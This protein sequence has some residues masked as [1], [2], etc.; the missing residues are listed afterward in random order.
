MCFT[1]LSRTNIDVVNNVRK[2]LLINNYEYTDNCDY[3]EESELREIKMESQALTVVQ[4]NIRGLFGKRD[5]LLKFLNGCNKKKIDIV[6]LEETWLNTQNNAQFSV[7]GYNFV[8]HARPNKKGG[9]VGILISNEIKYRLRK[10]LLIE[11]NPHFEN[12]S[13]EIKTCSSESILS[14]IYRPPN[15]DQKLF[16]KSFTELGNKV[17]LEKNKEWIIGLDHNMDLI[18]SEQHANTE[19]FLEEILRLELYPLITCPT[20]VTKS[21]ATLIDNILVSRSLYNK[22]SSAIIINDLSDHLPCI[23]VIDNMKSRKGETIELIKRDMKGE[24]IKQLRFALSKHNWSTIHGNIDVSAKFDYVHTTILRY[25]DQHCP[26][27]RIKI[28]NKKIIK[29]PWLFKGLIKCIDKQKKLYKQHL[30]NKTEEDTQRYKVYRRTL[31]KILRKRK[32]NHYQE[33]CIKY[34]SNTKRLWKMVNQITSTHNDKSTVINSIKVGNV[35]FTKPKDVTN[36][37]G[38]YFSSIGSNLANKTG[39]SKKNVNFY[40][41]QITKNNKS[42]FL[43]PCT[44]EEI[45][46]IINNIPNKKSSGYDGVSNALLKDLRDELL[47]PLTVVFNESLNQGVFP[48]TMKH[49]EVIPLFKTGLRNLATNYR[50]ISLLLTLSK[51]LEKL[52]YER[53]YKFLNTDQLYKSQYGFRSKHSC[54]DAVLELMS[55]VIKGWENNEHTIALFIDLSKAFDTLE[56]AVLFKKL[57]CYGIRGIALDWFKSYLTGRTLSVKCKV[58]ESNGVEISDHFPVNY[59]SPQGS[60]LGPLIFLVFCNDLY[61]VLDW[62]NCILFADDT[63]IYKSH[64]SPRFLECCLMED[65]TTLSD[66]FT[67]NKL[68]LNLN[69][70]VCMLF[71][72]KKITKIEIKMNNVVIP[73]VSNTKFLGIWIDEKLNWHVHTT[74]LIQKI[75]RNIHLLRLSGKILN[76]HTLKM[77]YYAQIFSHINYGIGLWG[78][79][80]SKQTI[81]KLQKLQN[82]CLSYVVRKN[83]I[84]NNDYSEIKVAPSHLRCSHSHTHLAHLG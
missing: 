74:K 30:I 29:E 64:K 14:C 21:S 50:P 5:D 46:R 69:K 33:Q 60:C 49:A 23:S 42:I 28:S 35:E 56:H 32:Q 70:T 20:R 36:K 80:T 78:N 3:L 16:I 75:S 73:Q 7:P 1:K 31:Q 11:S 61:H 13:V 62:C 53:V 24:N 82:K 47:V 76:R 45:T 71:S 40:I 67:A 57:E 44:V 79:L 12:I 66:W 19:T 43:E 52:V 83:K 84:N 26:E 17:Y 25:I 2:E 8:G 48:S 54:I 77:L 58:A 22:S 38:D 6:L 34:K 65:L 41:D 59:G 15:T 4:L 10:D 55:N 39:V 9:G 63:T 27:K 18:K 72:P 68:T 37:L 81:Q 51:I